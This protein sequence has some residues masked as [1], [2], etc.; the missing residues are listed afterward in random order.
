M[1]HFW[2]AS[3]TLCE[4]ELVRFFRQRSRVIGAFLPPVP[5]H[6]DW[7]SRSHSDCSAASRL[8]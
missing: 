4:R 7:R 6:I 5:T 8:A 2:L 3:W 1:T